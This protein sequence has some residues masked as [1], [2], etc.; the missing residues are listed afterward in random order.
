M[1][2]KQIDVKAKHVEDQSEMAPEL[3]EKIRTISNEIY[4]VDPRRQ[5]VYRDKVSWLAIF[6]R[7]VPESVNVAGIKYVCNSVE[8]RWRRLVILIS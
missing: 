1:P 6:Y 4:G 8:I 7:S 3:P 2:L 5:L